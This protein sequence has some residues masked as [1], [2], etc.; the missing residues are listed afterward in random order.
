M[1]ELLQHDAFS[2]LRYSDGELAGGKDCHES[3]RVGNNLQM[4][5]N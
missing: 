3:G 1:K 5:E 2:V 4:I